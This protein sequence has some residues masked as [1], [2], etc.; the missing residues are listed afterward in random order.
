[1]NSRAFAWGDF[2]LPLV[3][4]FMVLVV[5]HAV[6]A[7]VLPLH[8]WRFAVNMKGSYVSAWPPTCCKR[9]VRSPVK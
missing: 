4:L 6:I 3:V 9:S 7:M 8:G 5:L 2:L 1:M